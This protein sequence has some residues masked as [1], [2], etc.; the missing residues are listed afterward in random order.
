V[1]TSL[2]HRPLLGERYRIEALVGLGRL[3][4][5]KRRATAL[6][7]AWLAPATGADAASQVL[8]QGDVLAPLRAILSLAPDGEV[9]ALVAR[10]E[11]APPNVFIPEGDFF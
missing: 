11:A 7:H 9:A 10:V 1:C 4:E 2:V 6:A 5:A 3:E 8:L